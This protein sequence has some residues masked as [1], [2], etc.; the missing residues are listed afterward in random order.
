[1]ALLEGHIRSQSFLDLCAGHADACVIDFNGAAPAIEADT[2]LPYELV[3]KGMYF[4]NWD[5]G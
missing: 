4:R 2:D 1:M 3:E 5:R